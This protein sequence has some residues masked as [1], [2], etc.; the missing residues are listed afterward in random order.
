MKVQET[1][2]TLSFARPSRVKKLAAFVCVSGWKRNVRQDIRKAQKQ[3]IAI[4]WLTLV[5]VLENWN[6]KTIYK[7]IPFTIVVAYVYHLLIKA[8]PTRLDP[9]S[10]AVL[11]YFRSMRKRFRVPLR[12]RD[13]PTPLSNRLPDPLEGLQM[14]LRWPSLAFE[15]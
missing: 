9:F 11:A 1:S 14:I 3:F 8:Q 6:H 7:T 5:V 15:S 12:T 4:C 13:A 10:F 2:P